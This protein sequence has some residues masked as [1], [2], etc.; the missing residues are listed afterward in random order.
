MLTKETGFH[1]RTSK[2]TNDMMD[3]TGFWIPNK[4]N[5]Y[6]TI[7]EYTECRNNVVMMDLSSLRKFEIL[8]GCRRTSKCGLNTKCKKISCWTSSVHSYVLRKWNND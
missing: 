6:G 3:S 4:Y 5:N 7:K 8:S 1:P 2:L